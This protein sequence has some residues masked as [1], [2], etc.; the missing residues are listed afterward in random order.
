MCRISHL[1]WVRCA[2]WTEIIFAMIL[3]HIYISCLTEIHDWLIDHGFVFDLKIVL[4]NQFFWFYHFIECQIVDQILMSIHNY[5]QHI[6][7]AKW[8]PKICNSC[9]FLCFLKFC[10][11]EL[12]FKI[13][14]RCNNNVK[15]YNKSLVGSKPLHCECCF[16]IL[17]V[18]TMMQWLWLW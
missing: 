7:R 4:F 8:P 12:T 15:S 18:L 14:S 9:V 2:S 10:I 16:E 11:I 17:P 5:F 6:L 1:L 13:T 3:K